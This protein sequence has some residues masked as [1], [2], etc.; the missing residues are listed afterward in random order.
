MALLG[1]ALLWFGWF[2]FNAGSALALN[3]SA[4]VAFVN[5]NSAAAAGALAWMF[6]SW[7]R[8]KP[9]S[10]GMV[11]GAIAGM[12]AITPAAGFVTPLVAV[13]IGAVAGVLC[14][15]M[16]LVRIRRQ[17][18]ES[19]DAWAIHG[20]GG[21]WGTLATG[22]FA[23]AAIG[24]SAGLLEG[25]ASQFLVNALA[26]FAALGYA[27]IATWVIGTVIDRTIGLRVSEDEEYVGLDIC[28][29]GERA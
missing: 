9:S 4:V 7:Y 24:G 14:F 22:I 3:S 12:V 17:L 15:Y 2:G 8:G 27:F 26:A 18:D 10:L 28:Q 13:L 20:M 29:H 5:T 21:L 6:A 11:S 25:H 1:A 16:M 23:A 19:L